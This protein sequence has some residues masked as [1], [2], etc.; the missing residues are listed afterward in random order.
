MALE[1]TW[2]SSATPAHDYPP[3]SRTPSGLQR[4]RQSW[5]SGATVLSHSQRPSAGL[6][7]AAE[8]QDKG[9]ARRVGPTR[10]KAPHNLTTPRGVPSTITD[11]SLTNGL[12]Q[13]RGIMESTCTAVV[14][15]IAAALHGTAL[16]GNAIRPRNILGVCPRIRAAA[17]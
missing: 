6:I 12:A 7:R 9:F 10:D 8:R 13:G 1:S 4:S 11:T 17:L 2:V 16:E 3:A 14:V 5:K 15:E